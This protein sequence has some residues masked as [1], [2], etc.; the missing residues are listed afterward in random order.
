MWYCIVRASKKSWP[1]G[2]LNHFFEHGNVKRCISFVV[3]L[4]EVIYSEKKTL[5]G[6]LNG[7]ALDGQHIHIYIRTYIKYYSGFLALTIPG[8]VC[9]KLQID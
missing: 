3:A 1:L 9:P 4:T 6:I 2:F 8:P 7:T 5:R